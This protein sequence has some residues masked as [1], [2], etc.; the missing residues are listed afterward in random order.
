VLVLGRLFQHELVCA[1][2][3]LA[4]HSR[5]YRSLV[6]PSVLGWNLMMNACRGSAASHA[7]VLTAPGT[8]ANCQSVKLCVRRLKSD[9]TVHENRLAAEMRRPDPAK[10]VGAA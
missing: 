9:I 7:P 1:G 5:S 8:L 6:V 4:G 10:E 2:C 3:C